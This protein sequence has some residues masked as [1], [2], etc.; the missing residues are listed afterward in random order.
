MRLWDLTCPER[1]GQSLPSSRKDAAACCGRAACADPEKAGQGGHYIVFRS[2]EGPDYQ[3]LQEDLKEYAANLEDQRWYGTR[4][5]QPSRHYIREMK[6]YGVLPAD[7][8]PATQDVD[9]F[10]LDRKYYEIF[11]P[12]GR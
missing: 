10:E 6:R 1:N 9:A 3:A 12:K 7:F 2:P 4:N 8:D 5:W 11:Y